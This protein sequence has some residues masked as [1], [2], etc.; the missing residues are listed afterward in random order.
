M[1]YFRQSINK[2]A[3]ALDFGTFTNPPAIKISETK[4]QNCRKFVQYFK[5]R[6]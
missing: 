4:K 5:F 6:Y 3:A 2:N 1:L